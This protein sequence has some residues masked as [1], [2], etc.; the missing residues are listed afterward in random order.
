MPRSHANFL[1][2]DLSFE[3]GWYYTE[4][5]ADLLYQNEPFTRSTA[6]ALRDRPSISLMKQ[7]QY[8]FNLPESLIRLAASHGLRLSRLSAIFIPEINKDSMVNKI[9]FSQMILFLGR[10]L[11]SLSKT[12]FRKIQLPK[13]HR[14]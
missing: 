7:V 6:N 8:I 10:I 3:N 14:P 13:I 9:L 1:S 12:V 2:D 5:S 11:F 4:S